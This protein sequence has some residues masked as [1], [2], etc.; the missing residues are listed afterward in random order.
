MLGKRRLPATF[1]DKVVC[2]QARAP[3]HAR[4]KLAL[5]EVEGRVTERGHLAWRFLFLSLR[6]E[7]QPFR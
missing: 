5:S 7:N 1:V 2:G 4:L 6:P 3:H